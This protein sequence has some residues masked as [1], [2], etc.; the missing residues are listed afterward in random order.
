MSTDAAGNS[1]G[2]TPSRIE[3][4]DVIV[5]GGGLAGYCAAVEAADHGARVV[6]FE[7]EARI[8][9]ATVLSGGS[10]AFAGTDLQA[11]HGHHDSSELLFEDLRNVGGYRNDEA[12]VR[13]YVDQQHDAYCWLGALGVTFERLF[14]ASGQSVPRAH[15]RNPSDVLAR[16]VAAAEARGVQTRLS[17]RVR[18]LLRSS[19]DGPVEGVEV[20]S[21]AGRTRH[22]AKRGVV[23]AT[24]GF[25][26]NERLLELFAPAQA[27]AQRMGGAGNQGDGLLLAWKLGAALKDMGY[28]KGTFGSH[29]SAGPEDHF[30]LFPIY[31]GAIAV[32]L[33]GRRFTD[34]SRSYKLIGDACLRQRG[35]R[36][37]QV[38]DHAIFGASNDAIPSMAF[39]EYLDAGRVIRAPTLAAL[40]K[41]MEVDA[42][43]LEASVAKYNAAV[44]AG[45]A[46]AFGRASL[47][48]GFG[49][50]VRIDQPPFYAYASTSV[51]LATYCGLAVDTQMRVL[52]VFDE[53]IEGLC[54]AGGV[55]GGFH[56]V[57]YMTGTANG[58]AT[59][60]G[61]I[62]G[63]SVATTAPR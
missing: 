54:A 36:A 37:F 7:R 28:I 30:I 33:D 23:L 31:A 47:C 29:P 62:A 60:F 3:S 10:F 38:F 51:V 11:R 52:D 13:A 21:A 61:R 5:V 44:A 45:R 35:H 27:H 43:A 63:R 22:I 1:A 48:S 41:A 24:G 8:G 46:D 56:G 4:T 14:I 16:V 39:R 59:I 53:V 32:N 42:G 18:R 15:S 50:L 17:C 25:S 49:A 34:E 40:A 6:L 57:A 20:D 2:G 9:G 26:R 58:K 55:V 12:L 19:V